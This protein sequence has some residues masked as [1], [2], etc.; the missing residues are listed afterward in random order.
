[1][2]HIGPR[3]SG[4]RRDGGSQQKSKTSPH[5]RP[6][7]QNVA[8]HTAAVSVSELRW[9]APQGKKPTG[10]NQPGRI[11]LKPPPAQTKLS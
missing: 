9:P 3:C 7:A 1:H 2:L 5:T 11:D 8:A 10:Q 4:E 6:S